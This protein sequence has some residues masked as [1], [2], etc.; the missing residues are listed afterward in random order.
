MAR[1][2]KPPRRRR[3]EAA[4]TSAA[5]VSSSATD[6]RGAG[7]QQEQDRQPKRQRRI[8]VGN[9]VRD[10]A[11]CLSADDCDPLPTLQECQDEVPFCCAVCQCSPARKGRVLMRDAGTNNY[12]PA[13]EEHLWTQPSK[14]DGLCWHRRCCHGRFD[15]PDDNNVSS[16]DNDDD[17]EEQECQW[18]PQYVAAEEELAQEITCETNNVTDETVL[19]WVTSKDIHDAYD[20]TYKTVARQHNEDR[21]EHPLAKAMTNEKFTFKILAPFKAEQERR[22]KGPRRA[23]VVLDLF[24]GIGTGIV[25]LKK[26]NIAIKR[27]IHVEHDKV[28]THVYRSNHDANY[29]DFNLSSDGIEHVYVDRFEDIEKELYDDPNLFLKKYGPIDIILGGPPCVDFSAIN[30][31]RKGTAG[32]QGKYMLQC[33]KF[34]RTIVRM[35]QTMKHSVFFL[36]ENVVTTRKN[37]DDICKA[38]GMDWDPVRLNAEKV[39]PCLRDRHYYTNIPPFLQG[40][41]DG[42]D[43]TRLDPKP[44]CCLDEG[45]QVGQRLFLA[46]FL[47][48]RQFTINLVI[49]S[50]DSGR[51]S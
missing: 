9:Q 47:F 4:A 36:A 14:K 18:A 31:S 21:T 41:E 15:V 30:A 46:R 51:Y 6:T 29:S 27:I 39:S 37:L 12:V 7:Q 49:L 24:A 23:A 28:A 44:T 2:P 20:N 25:C 16:S 3:T 33:G 8:A 13:D 17:E 5:A 48:Q 19:E 38:F 50:S 11:K 22:R 10:R 26:Q 35:Q 32:E 40:L 42:S 34:I 45:F 43:G 1:R